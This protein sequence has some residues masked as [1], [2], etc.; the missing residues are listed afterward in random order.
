MGPPEVA[1][2]PKHL[3]GDLGAGADRLQGPPRD[4]L[5]ENG[6]EGMLANQIG[7][8][9]REK[10]PAW[11]DQKWY[12]DKNRLGMMLAAASNGFGNMTLRGNSGMKGHK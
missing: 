3:L 11:I 4:Q 7:V 8:P 5:Q 9:E 10:A 6:V 12:K 2:P 1:G